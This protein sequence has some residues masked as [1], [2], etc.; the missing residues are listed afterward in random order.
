[1]T[2]SQ[3]S[4]GAGRRTLIEEGSEFKGSIR[5][6]CPIVV[7]G[8][9]EGE[10]ETPSLSVSSTG[11]VHGRA[12]VG[13]VR[14]EGELAGE[15]DADSISL[16]GSV[17]DNTVIRARSLEV[18]LS[19]EN[20]KMQ[21]VFGEVELSVGEQPTDDGSV[22]RTRKRSVPSPPAEGSGEG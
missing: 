12:K 3:A 19:S 10:V 13:E 20:G 4:A 15:F 17:R 18:K 5:S 21:V 14:S 1:M 2:M 11:A 6:S 22:R 8:R 7:N 9:I 16:S